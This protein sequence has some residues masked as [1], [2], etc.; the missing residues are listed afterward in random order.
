MSIVHASVQTPS[1]AAQ[2]RD[3]EGRDIEPIAHYWF[4]SG[5]AHLDFLGIDRNRL[6]KREDINERFQRA[7][8]TGDANQARLAF[9]ITLDGDFIGYT[10]LVRSDPQNNYSHW[11]I[12]DAVRRAGGISSALYPWRIK[13]YFDAAPLERLIHQTRT[14]NLPVNRLL[15]IFAPVAETVQIDQPDGVAL[16]G[17]FH[18]RYV[19]RADIPRFFEIAARRNDAR[20]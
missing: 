14:R 3:L 18:I 6:G 16:P 7:I 1:G 9:A 13:T 10:L 20:K 11:H 17:E 5:D 12:T 2:L 19:H 15:D 4:E 8:P